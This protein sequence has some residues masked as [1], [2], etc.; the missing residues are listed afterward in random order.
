MSRLWIGQHSQFNVRSQAYCRHLNNVLS[1]FPFWTQHRFQ[2]RV[3]FFWIIRQG[4]KIVFEKNVITFRLLRWKRILGRMSNFL[5]KSSCIS[6]ENV[7]EKKTFCF[8]H[9]NSQHTFLKLGHMHHGCQIENHLESSTTSSTSCFYYSPK[10]KL[11]LQILPFP[12]HS[13]FACTS[14]SV[15][16]N[17]ANYRGFNLRQFDLHLHDTHTHR[18]WSTKRR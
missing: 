2:F 7:T 14:N 4:M 5:S 17:H 12:S 6:T 13:S 18:I 11:Q 9:T 15:H 10:W 8:G 16:S 3:L 1:T